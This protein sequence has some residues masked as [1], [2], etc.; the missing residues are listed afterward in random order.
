MASRDGAFRILIGAAVGMCSLVLACDAPQE[1]RPEDLAAIQAGP[2]FTPMTV[3]PE[4]RNRDE[5]NQTLMREYPSILRDAGIG[6]R[7][8]VIYYI[9]DKGQ[10]LHNRVQES[11]GHVELDR[12]ALRVAA[13]SQFTPA[14]NRGERVAVWIHLP[15]TFEVQ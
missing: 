5:V 8:L 9:S 4:L 13:V 1:I 12:A 2:V 6:G 14:E 10:V 3:R 7:V 15:I 11:S